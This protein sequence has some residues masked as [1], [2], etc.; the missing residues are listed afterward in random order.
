MSVATKLKAFWKRRKWIILGGA[1]IVVAGVSFGA[2][3]MTHG[4]PPVP[5]A[6]V[7][8][9]EF[10]D[11]VQIRGE[12]T[13]LK[14]VTLNAPAVS[15]DI[16]IL[17]LVKNGTAVKK[18]DV[19]VQLDVAK[20][21]QTLAQRRSEM[22]QA[23]A[24][25]EQTR[26]KARL[27]AE[28][29]VTDLQKSRYDVERA[30]LEVSKAEIVSKIEG[31]EKKI[32]LS[33]AE[34]KLKESEQ[35]VKSD[36]EGAAADIQA[37]Q[38]KRD[39]ALFDVKQA[40][41]DIA[42]MIL[43]A[44]ED[45]MVS[46]LRNFRAGGW[47]SDSAPE[48]KEG[49]RAWSGAGIAE[50]PD[51]TSLQL[52]ARIDEADRGRLKPAQTATV[53][54]DAVPDKEFTARVSE[55]SPLAKSDFSSWPILKNFDLAMQFDQLDARLRPGMSANARVA[56]ERLADSI[57]VPPEALFP[58]G[59]KTVAYVWAG[60]KFEE[61]ATEVARRGEKQVAVARGLKPG[62]QVALKDP[63]LLEKT[64]KK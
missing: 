51:L 25:I 53:R 26:A 33:N 1:A 27:Q 46:L 47:F 38:D 37:R 10:V 29:D 9:G 54:V 12:L 60:S 34:Q 6:E 22:K 30:K 35:K 62:E 52:R 57:L 48:F 8:R 61:R 36:R 5:T 45:G 7:K 3:R 64:E 23:D 39:K 55:I 58:K 49:D 19:V 50:L 21:Q 44:P 16:Q 15:V 20:L 56:I 59:G 4:A 13:A 24:E 32:E 41:R 28:Q 43:R 14:S 40:E 17:K 2:V 31:E 42:S 11:T 18:G 63:T